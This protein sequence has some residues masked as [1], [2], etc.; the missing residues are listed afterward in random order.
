MALSSQDLIGDSRSYLLPLL[1]LTCEK[2]AVILLFGTALDRRRSQVS[3][4]DKKNLSFFFFF[5]YLIAQNTLSFNAEL[6]EFIYFVK[7]AGIQWTK[8]NEVHDTA[9]TPLY[10]HLTGF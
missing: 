1:P 7:G 5:F 9:W 3:I 8:S 2:S 4:F 10:L 6:H